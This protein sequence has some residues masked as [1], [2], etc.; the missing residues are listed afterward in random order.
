MKNAKQKSNKSRERSNK[1]G[2][3]SN[4]NIVGQKS[5]KVRE[6]SNKREKSNNMGKNTKTMENRTPAMNRTSVIFVSLMLLFVIILSG[7][8]GS[9]KVTVSTTDNDGL[10]I[11]DFS[12][13]FESY[14]DDEEIVL[15]GTIEN[16]GGRTAENVNVRLLGASWVEDDPEQLAELQKNYGTMSPPDITVDPQIPGDM[17]QPTWTIPAPNLPEGIKKDFRLVMRA[18]YYYATTSVANIQALGSD[19]YKRRVAA[20]ETVG[21]LSIDTKN[22]NGPI[23]IEMSG[24]NPMK[25]D[26]PDTIRSG[27]EYEYFTYRIKF[28]NVGSGT[29]ITEGVDG[30]VLGTLT[31]QGEGVEFSDCFG[32]TQGKVVDLIS[33]HE[34]GEDLVKLR[35]GQSIEKP[36]EV[37][38]SRDIWELKSEDVATFI[39]DLFYTYYTDKDV[40]VLVTG[41]LDDRDLITPDTMI[42]SAELIK[43]SMS[44]SRIDFKI[45]GND[46]P[47]SSVYIYY[48]GQYWDDKTVLRCR[49]TWN[50]VLKAGE[51]YS[52]TFENSITC[53]EGSQIVISVRSSKSYPIFSNSM[54]LTSSCTAL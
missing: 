24:A 41:K 32:V 40:T 17:K 6:K 14:E 5:S 9:K 25:I 26:A 53:A 46:V 23:K 28:N 7:C 3:N 1:S 33:A 39:Y 16:L 13:D 8:I 51:T 15:Y 47:K 38:V 45:N 36:C 44:S 18:Q 21:G 43:T 29:P 27:D 34:I 4:N 30:L 49:E 50:D 12:A 22:S 42:G 20:G 11:T 48:L 10:V 37:K 35:R 2:K 52:C 54:F 31:I 19:E